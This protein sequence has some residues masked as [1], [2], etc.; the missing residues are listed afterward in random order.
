[1]RLTKANSSEP[2]RTKESLRDPGKLG[3]PVSLRDP[4]KLSP[5][6]GSRC[7]ADGVWH[8]VSW[9][10]SSERVGVGAK[11]NLGSQAGDVL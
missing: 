7:Y 11:G 5:H 1:M 4:G 2:K 8:A 3:M 6:A 10:S 9:A